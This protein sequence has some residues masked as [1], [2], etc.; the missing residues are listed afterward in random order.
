MQNNQKPKLS[1]ALKLRCLYCGTQRLLPPGRWFVL[2]KGC[3]DC[4]YDYERE[5]GYFSGAF[6]MILFT[7]ISLTAILVALGLKFFAPN[8]GAIGIVIVCSVVIVAQAI[9]LL[10][11]AMA[12]WM[13]MDHNL[14]PLEKKGL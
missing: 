4:A 10:P 6:Q 13:W 1:N 5:V 3:V 2:E 12:L 8:L 9:L 11:W 14:H 7:I